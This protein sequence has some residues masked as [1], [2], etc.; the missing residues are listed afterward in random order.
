MSKS[1]YEEERGGEEGERVGG[2]QVIT[3][4]HLRLWGK[5]GK[6]LEASPQNGREPGAR[7]SQH[8]KSGY[9]KGEKEKRET[10]E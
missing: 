9:E 8:D 3:K 7:E 4:N 2:V 5:T 6:P 1:G 10:K